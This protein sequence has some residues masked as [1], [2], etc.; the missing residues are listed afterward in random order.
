MVSTSLRTLS[1]VAILLFAGSAFAAPLPAFTARYQ[2]SKDGSPLGEATMTLAPAGDATWTFTTRSQGTEGLAALM[3]ANVQ[4]NSTFRW[5]GDAPE[6]LSYDYSMDAAIKHTERHV[7]FDWSAGTIDVDD[8][9]RHQFPA[10]PGTMERHTVVLAIAAG[11]RDGKQSFDLP[12]AVRDHVETQHYLV[13]GH[14][15]LTVPA[16]TYDAAHVV[17]RDGNGFEAWFTSKLPV[18]VQVSQND[19]GTL[20]MKLESYTAQ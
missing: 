11:L 2:L 14:E 18:P 8:K 5:K 15:N 10:Q 9:G 20:T 7:R 17:R 13:Q 1:T 16:G 6:G 12:V 19:N 4:E 3:S